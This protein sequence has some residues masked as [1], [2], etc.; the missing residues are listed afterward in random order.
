M[1]VLVDTSAWSLSLR[2]NAP[3]KSGAAQKLV[4]LI[5][6]DQDLVVTAVILQEVLRAFRSEEFAPVKN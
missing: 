1:R 3:A 5:E 4:A 2:R 6:D